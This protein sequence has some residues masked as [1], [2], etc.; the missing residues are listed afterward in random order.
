[1]RHTYDNVFNC[2]ACRD[3][4]ARLCRRVWMIATFIAALKIIFTNFN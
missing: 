3:M 1:M 2:P 4:A